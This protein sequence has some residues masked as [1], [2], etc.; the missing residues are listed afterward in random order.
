MSGILLVVASSALAVMG[1]LAVRRFL[2]A[3]DLISCHDVGG[4]LLSVVGT[5]YA[6]TL[7]LI[8]VDSMHRFQQARATT[9]QE[10]NA[11]ADVMLL[12]DHLPGERRERI[13][14]LATAYIDQVVNEEWRTMDQ[15]KHSPRARAAAIRLVDSVVAFE[16][17]TEKEKAAYAAQLTAICQFWDSRRSRTL[18]ASHGIP[19][20]EWTVLVI[21][22]VITVAFT[23]FFKLE[24]LK[25]QLVMTSLV[26]TMIVLNI[27]L[28]LMFGYPF[29][30]DLKVD[31][32]S[33]T[34]IKKIIEH[35][36]ENRFEKPAPAST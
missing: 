10:T 21:G 6:V 27:F 19:T 31:N 23:Y 16:P 18:T 33:F 22:G 17:R 9:D 3:R 12:S 13:R 24:H 1:L 20:L 5:L 15:G 32:D 30:G 4:Y 28:V 7:G 29:S 8:V 25:I 2:R 11:L 36:D 26:A 14:Q 35:Q 34:I